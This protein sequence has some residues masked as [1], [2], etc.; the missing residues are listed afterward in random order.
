MMEEERDL[1]A[2]FGEFLPDDE[3]IQHEIEREWERR[4]RRGETIRVGEASTSVYQRWF[5][6]WGIDF[7]SVL[8][9]KGWIVEDEEEEGDGDEEG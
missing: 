5:L 8:R 1:E 6:K 9:R 4:H 7:V 3:E 2:I